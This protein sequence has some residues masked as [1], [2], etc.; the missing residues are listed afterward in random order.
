MK[1]SMGLLAGL[2]LLVQMIVGGLLFF[3]IILVAVGVAAG[4]RWLEASG[5]VPPWMAIASNYIEMAAFG[6]DIVV[7]GL[8][9]VV[10]AIKT[11]RSLITSGAG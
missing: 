1:L 8:F 2:A 6:I 4:V 5:V 3:G 11:G 7:Y 9:V 10:E